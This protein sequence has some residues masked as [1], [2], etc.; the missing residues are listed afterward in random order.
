MEIG[1]EHELIPH[2]ET[3]F[4]QEYIHW[5]CGGKPHAVSVEFAGTRLAYPDR[6]TTVGIVN[7]EPSDEGF[8]I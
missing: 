7:D 3:G 4:I 2:L 6:E 5:V 8:F 1:V